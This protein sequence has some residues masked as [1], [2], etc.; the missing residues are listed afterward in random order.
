MEPDFRGV[1]VWTILKGTGSVSGSMLVGGVIAIKQDWWKHTKLP[2]NPK[3][4]CMG[5]G[6]GAWQKQKDHRLQSGIPPKSGTFLAGFV[7][8]IP[9]SPAL[10]GIDFG[11]LARIQSR[12]ASEAGRPRMQL[13]DPPSSQW[14]RRDKLYTSRHGTQ[15]SLHEKGM[16]IQTGAFYGFAHAKL[17]KRGRFSRH[18]HKERFLRDLVGNIC[19]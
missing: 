3:N 11:A 9:T 14:A 10:P 12:S 19:W 15:C 18:C 1:L 16:T 5:R 7:P 8:F 4:G 13:P 2:K 17:Q 6:P